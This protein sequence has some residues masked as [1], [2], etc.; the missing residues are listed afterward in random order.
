MMDK[1]QE[2]EAKAARRARGHRSAGR[3]VDIGPSRALPG[4]RARYR[5]R[6][7]VPDRVAEREPVIDDAT[8]AAR[9]RSR[10][11]STC[12]ARWSWSAPPRRGAI[13]L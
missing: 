1:L 2:R 5:R 8:C 3:C 11:M 13:Y 12:S 6:G 4:V 7:R 10:A 9:R